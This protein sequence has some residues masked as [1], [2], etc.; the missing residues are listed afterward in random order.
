[1]IGSTDGGGNRRFIRCR[2]T[3]H[4]NNESFISRVLHIHE[5]KHPPISWAYTH[6][7]QYQ[8]T[9]RTSTSCAIYASS[10]QAMEI[11]ST[12]P[13]FNYKRDGDQL[14]A[15][16]FDGTGKKVSQPPESLWIIDVSN[17]EKRTSSTLAYGP[18]SLGSRLKRVL[19]VKCCLCQIVATTIISG[20]IRIHISS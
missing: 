11:R 18:T 13:L 17:D 14:E 6:V 3:C 12:M 2:F 5:W 9:R 8:Y 16:W 19:E 4:K 10:L 15:R 7:N 1:M 20:L